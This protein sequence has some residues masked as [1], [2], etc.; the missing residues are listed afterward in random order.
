MQKP[1]DAQ[2][3]QLQDDFAFIAKCNI[4]GVFKMRRFYVSEQIGQRTW[5][6]HFD[7]RLGL[8]LLE[9]SLIIILRRHPCTGATTGR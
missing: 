9:Q 4:E 1:S 3:A 5:L 6:R 8:S 7:N 2:Y